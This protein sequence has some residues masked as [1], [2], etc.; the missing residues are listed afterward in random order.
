MN[1]TAGEI[2]RACRGEILCDENIT[3]NDIVTDSRKAGNGT[4]FVAISGENVDGHDFVGSALE[5][6]AAL[7][8]VNREYKSEE[9]KII[10]VDDTVAALG[11]IAKYYKSK[12]DVKTTA[13]TGSVGKTTT[14]DMISSVFNRKYKTLTTKGNFNNH[15]GLPLTIFGLRKEHE[16]ALTEMGM[17]GFGEIHYLAD[18][19]RPDTAVISN[20]GLSHIEKLGSREGIL[21]AKLEICD[22][23]DDNSTLIVN[24]DD[25][26]LYPAAKKL[27]YRVVSFGI[28]NPDADFKAYDIKDNGINGVEFSVVIYDKEHRINVKTAGV[29]NVYNALAAVCAGVNYGISAEDIKIGI[30]EYI[31]SGMRMN[32]EDIGGITVINDC[33]N[34]CP[35]SVEAGLNVLKSAEANRR[36]AMLGDMLEIGEYSKDAHFKAGTLAAKCADCLLCAGNEADNMKNGA[37]KGGIKEAHTFAN[38]SELAA[39]A[40]D[41]V[42][43]GDAVLIKASRGMKFEVIYKEILNKSNIKK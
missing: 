4:A 22:F 11:D 1:L 24:G 2:A 21:K 18:I 16:A 28:K 43:P 10:K 19:A 6:G 33:Y 20:I 5:S 3:V 14:K 39:F 38:S 35:A 8:V 36:I 23:F 41:Y 31:S 13:V 25:E 34:A 12:F 30:E 9:T 7:A 27:P 17:S 40:E 15:I 37:L 42:S 32:I 26:L 29:H